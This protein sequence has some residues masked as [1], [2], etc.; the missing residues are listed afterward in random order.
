MHLP[1]N[2]LVAFY[3]CAAEGEVTVAPVALFNL[4]QV[5]VFGVAGR[6]ILVVQM[7]CFP[8]TSFS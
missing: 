6:T 5:P 2:I 4:Q 1:C 3:V 8:C 7:P